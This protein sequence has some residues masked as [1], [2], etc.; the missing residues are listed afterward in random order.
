MEIL[1]ERKQECKP[2][3]A[4]TVDYF[5]GAEFLRRSSEVLDQVGS[6]GI[7]G[8]EFGIWAT[9]YKS[10]IEAAAVNAFWGGTYTPTQVTI[11][12]NYV[13]DVLYI[14]ANDKEVPN[15]N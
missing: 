11:Y 7:V 1:S 5:D 6:A 4:N 10:G 12:Q 13:D 9:G 14:A 2:C 15:G 3:L 8:A